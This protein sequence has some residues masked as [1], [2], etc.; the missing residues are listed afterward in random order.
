LAFIILTNRWPAHLL[1][2]PAGPACETTPVPPPVTSR[3][4]DHPVAFTPKVL[5]EPI[6]ARTSTNLIVPVQEHFYSGAPLTRQM[7]MKS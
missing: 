5:L 4:R 3:P 2:D 6:P 7:P 1:F